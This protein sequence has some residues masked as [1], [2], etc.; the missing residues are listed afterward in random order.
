MLRSIYVSTT[1]ADR[2]ARRASLKLALERAGFAVECME[3]D[4]D[5]EQGP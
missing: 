4:A 1:F 2:E 5:F 3:K